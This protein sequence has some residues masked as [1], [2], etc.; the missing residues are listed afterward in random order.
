M[1]PSD[2]KRGVIPLARR[3]RVTSCP[4]AVV[5]IGEC[6]IELSAM[7]GGTAR[8]GAAGD[9]LNTATYVARLGV[10]VSY[11]TAI[12]HDPFSRE[13]LDQWRADGIDTSMV[14]TDPHRLPGVYAVRTDQRGERTFF[15]WREQSAARNLFALGVDTMLDRAADARILYL[16]GITL[17]LFDAAGRAR[18]RNLACRVRERGGQVAFDMNYRA[19]GWKSVEDARQAVTQFAPY[20][21]IALPTHDDERLVH[22]DEDAHATAKRWR[23][24]GAAEVVV[25]LG[26]RGCLIA[27]EAG[28]RVVSPAAHVLAVDTTGA[29][30][31]F[32]AGYLAARWHGY[33]RDA[34]AMFANELAGMVVRHPGAILPSNLMPTFPIPA[35][36]SGDGA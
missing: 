21:S 17:S 19:A 22:G 3:T 24:S 16:T 34:A 11:F 30:D 9:T 33:E 29:G 2:E 5:V 1:T 15:Y 12:G 25:K 35:E 36:V 26:A 18:L 31:A 20:V 32:N 23:R 4:T 8:V 6:M 14:L 7:R 28:M 27:D 13:M 10:G